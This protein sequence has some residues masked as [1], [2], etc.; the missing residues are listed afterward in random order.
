MERFPTSHETFAEVEPPSD[1]GLDLGETHLSFSELPTVDFKPQAEGE[2]AAEF[3]ERVKGLEQRKFIGYFLA[4]EKGGPEAVEQ[5]FL[6]G[7]FRLKRTQRREF[8]TAIAHMPAKEYEARINSLLEVMPRNREAIETTIAQADSIWLK[9]RAIAIQEQE[10]AASEAAPIPESPTET[11]T[12]PAAPEP[13]EAPAPALAEVP[14]PRRMPHFESAPATPEAA[15]RRAASR[16]YREAKHAR[17]SKSF[18]Q[19]L[20]EGLNDFV[21]SSIDLEHAGESRRERER[22]LAH[23]AELRALV[24]QSVSPRRPRFQESYAPGTFGA[25]RPKNGYFQQ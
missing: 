25:P 8:L 14:T 18:W 6:Q 2:T 20:G 16:A 13:A 19:K 12:T 10:L 7:D 3:A 24:K 22:R 11:E 23:E 17:R 9:G 1:P 21:H 5:A 15:P 4:Q